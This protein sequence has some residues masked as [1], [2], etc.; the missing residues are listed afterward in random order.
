MEK[1]VIQTLDPI[2][3]SHLL[4][5]NDLLQSLPLPVGWHLVEP[6]VDTQMKPDEPPRFRNEL[7]GQVLEHHPMQQKIQE[8]VT[9]V[10]EFEEQA[11]IRVIFHFFLEKMMIS[12]SFSEI[13]LSAY[14]GR[15]TM[16]TAGVSQ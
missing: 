4:W 3:H 8:L 15:K 9:R 16:R 1:Y 11:K 14:L 12:C 7:T 10:I 5:L 13:A 2:Q 6:E